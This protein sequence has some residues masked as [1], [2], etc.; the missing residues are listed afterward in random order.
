VAAFCI[1]LDRKPTGN[2]SVRLLAVPALSAVA[3][4]LT[5]IGLG[6]YASL[7]SVG[8]RGHYFS[9]WAV[10]NLL[11]GTNLGV[12]VLLVVVAV[13]GLRGPRSSWFDIGCV[14]LAGAFAVWSERTVPVAAILLA[15][16]A[17]RAIQ[18]FLAPPTPLRRA[19]LGS[20]VAL[21]VVVLGVLAVQIPDRDQDPVPAWVDAELAALPAGTPVLTSWNTGTYF[22][23]SQPHLE[24]V[25]HGYGDV[26]T[27]AEIARNAM[28][29]EQ[30]PGW[31]EALSELDV[32]LA[33][34]E[35]AAALA[36]AL[37]DD[38]GWAVVR[39]DDDFRVLAPPA[40]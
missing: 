27:D 5:P 2:E 3:A 15:P 6:A 11:S 1:C 40:P 33:V 32:E 8:S 16:L 20:V 29:N 24:P 34:V 26:F 10:P 22:T 14:L 37:V 12:S 36:D 25:M 23:W 21:G 31:R 4:A 38:A 13:A 19:E 7:F 18:Q 39:E 35:R 28:L 9:E 17:A 30:T